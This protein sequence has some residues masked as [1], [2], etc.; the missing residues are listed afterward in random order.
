MTEIKTKELAIIKSIVKT[1]SDSEK[2]ALSNW[3]NGLLEIRNSDLPNK[4]KATKA[5]QLTRDSKIVLPIIKKLSKELKRISWDERS[6]RMRIGLSASVG[7][8]LTLGNATGGFAAMG[9]AIA[10][11]LWIVLGGGSIIATSFI[12]EIIKSKSK[13]QT[14]YSVI[15]A[16][17]K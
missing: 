15:D 7:A 13:N 16:K 10:V 5:I 6:W 8:L 12:E 1:A 11:P 3:A 14:D 9:T 4:L 2:E 17:K